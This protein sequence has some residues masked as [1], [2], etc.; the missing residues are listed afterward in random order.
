MGDGEG[1]GLTWG[2]ERRA[3]WLR[4]RA[5][6]VGDGGAPA[7]AGISRSSEP[8][9]IVRPLYKQRLNALA[10]RQR[11]SGSSDRT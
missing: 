7:G 4:A 9:R 1:T 11:A 3:F 8:L 5:G 6:E 10:T 2:I